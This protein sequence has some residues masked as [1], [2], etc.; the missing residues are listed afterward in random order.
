VW[1]RGDGRDEIVKTEMKEEGSQGKGSSIRT[2]KRWCI[3]IWNRVGGL[4]S[5]MF[6][7][8]RSPSNILDESH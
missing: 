3:L 1:S 7:A 8:A 2:L 5:C 4:V 6:H